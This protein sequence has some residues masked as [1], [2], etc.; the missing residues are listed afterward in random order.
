MSRLTK[1]RALKWPTIAYEVQKNLTMSRH[2]YTAMPV[3]MN[4]AKFESL[5]PELQKVLI[6]SAQ[7]AGRLQRDLNAKDETRM[8]AD[9]KSKGMQVLETY[10]AAPFRRLVSGETRK[11][12][13]EKNGGELLA[14]VDATR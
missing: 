6:D 2:A 14:A 11:A 5:S 8:V 9:L 13:V 3:V 12:F 1:L 4:K 10:D 7:A